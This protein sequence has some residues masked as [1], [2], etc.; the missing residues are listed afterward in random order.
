MADL[1]GNWSVQP[2]QNKEEHMKLPAIALVAGLGLFAAAP[3]A[4]QDRVEL[5]RT[6]VTRTTTTTTHDNGQ[7]LGWH[8]RKVCRTHWV[9]HRKVT[10]CTWKRWR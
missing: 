6:E 10:R 3:L 2:A 5:H 9:H 8:K 7:H 4:A 1:L